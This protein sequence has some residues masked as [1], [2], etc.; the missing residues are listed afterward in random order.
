MVELVLRILRK[1]TK[2]SP[3]MTKSGHICMKDA[4]LAETNEISIF[5]FLFFK[6]WSILYSKFTESSKSFDLQ[7]ILYIKYRMHY[8][9]CAIYITVIA[10][11]FRL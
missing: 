2:I 4:H 5:R 7:I 11:L 1:L 3:H 6:L 10:D 8:Q 9:I